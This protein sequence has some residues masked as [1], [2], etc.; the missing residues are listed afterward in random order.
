MGSPPCLRRKG[1]SLPPG[2]TPRSPTP[3]LPSL[4]P[5]LRPLSSNP[6]SCSPRLAH[7]A[8]NSPPSRAAHLILA[9][10]RPKSCW[11]DPTRDAACGARA[12]E[13]SA[14]GLRTIAG[15]LP[16]CP[17]IVETQQCLR[18]GPT[19]RTSEQSESEPEAAP[20]RKVSRDCACVLTWR[21]R[22]AALP[23]PA[24]SFFS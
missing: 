17:Q 5:L 6:L 22:V 18:S 2:I 14:N 12:P 20:G 13:D 24:C 19:L 9:L 3:V 8:E 23:R 16:H 4:S 15:A 10:P 11:R 7:V 1:P 21:L